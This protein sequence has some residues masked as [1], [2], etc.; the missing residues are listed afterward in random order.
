[1]Q[2]AHDGFPC[3]EFYKQVNF[4]TFEQIYTHDYRVTGDTPEAMAGEMEY[5]FKKIL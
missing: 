1:M 2:G 5:S 4:G 3:F